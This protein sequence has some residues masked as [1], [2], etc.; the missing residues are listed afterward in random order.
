MAIDK[1][2][3]KQETVVGDDVVLE[4]INPKSSTISV[5]DSSTGYTLDQTID[6]IWNAI[7]GKL[8]RVVNSVNGRTGVVVLSSDDVGLGNVDNVSLGDIK[9][10]VINK[11]TEEFG[12]KRL[13][14]FDTL[15]D[16]DSLI[17][18]NNHIYRDTPFFSTHGYGED[19]KSYIGYIYL[20]EG[21]DELKF[22]A[23]AINTVGYT[24][25]SLIYDEEINDKDMTGGGLGVNIWKYEDALKVYNDASGNKNESG[26]MI[27][28]SKISSKLIWFDGVYGNGLPDDTNSFLYYD[29]TTTPDNS[30]PVK[31]FINE[32]QI[33]HD[34][35]LC[36][37]EIKEGDLILCNFKDYRFRD[38][39]NVI[40]VRDGMVR[41]LMFRNPCIGRVERILSDLN[42]DYVIKFYSIKP[43]I[44]W[45]LKYLTD[46]KAGITD[47]ELTIKLSRGYTEG[48]VKDCNISG[49]QVFKDHDDPNPDNIESETDLGENAQYTVLPEGKVKILADIDRSS[50]GLSITPDYSLCIIPR[51]VYD[52]GE[53]RRIENWYVKS[54]ISG[55]ERP[56]GCL[57]D[58]SLLGINLFKA[59]DH[60]DT[61]KM[62]F[63]NLSGL[64]IHESNEKII[65][66]ST[67]GITPEDY[68]GNIDI[69]NI[70]TSGGLSVNV[71]KFLEISPDDEYQKSGESYYDGGKVNVR[72]GKGLTDSGYNK[73]DVKLGDTLIFNT[74]DAIEVNYGPGLCKGED[75]KI[76]VELPY[77][78]I[79]NYYTHGI[80]LTEH[81]VVGGSGYALDLMIPGTGPVLADPGESSITIYGSSSGHDPSSEDPDTWNKWKGVIMINKKKTLT[82]K[83]INNNSYLYDALDDTR[84]ANVDNVN[85]ELGPGLR[86]IL[87]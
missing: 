16:L 78:T 23:R 60:Y 31:I 57:E 77:S 26:L 66:N 29:P 15:H 32:R 12:N 62:R 45:G 69:E 4:D 3:L 85:I 51:S 21:T 35:R 74:T 46:H 59:V 11:I 36:Y 61:G 81:N 63:A 55:D 30:P 44:G 70:D 84:T 7:N 6:R 76:G 64:R 65:Y 73:I 10:W 25:N 34:F 33:V 49:L 86:L 22:K 75:G 82:F 48:F 14:L 47:N 79:F 68:K 28:K 17:S 52:Q 8:S 20:D 19:K 5:T 40:T 71:G 87:D 1:V 2:Q 13:K 54:P 42:E 58:F 41:E 56:K 18:I 37:T 50:G 43:N 53:N 83:D 9:K 72:I 67:L 24:D 27:D 39:K 38:D 80:A